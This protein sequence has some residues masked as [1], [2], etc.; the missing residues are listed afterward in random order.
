MNSLKICVFPDL[1]LSKEVKIGSHLATIIKDSAYNIANFEGSLTGEAHCRSKIGIKLATDIKYFDFFHCHNFKYVSM[2]NNHVFDYRKRGYLATVKALS[3]IGVESFGAGINSKDAQKEIII[4]DGGLRVSVIGVAAYSTNSLI[5][6]KHSFGCND[7]SY[8][9]LRSLASKTNANY[10]I[11]FA[12]VGIEQ[13]NYPEPYVRYVCE[14]LIEESCYDVII[15]CHAHALQGAAEINGRFVFYGLGNFLLPEIQYEGGK[16]GHTKN[17]DY[18]SFIVI[19]IENDKITAEQKYFEILENGT[20]AELIDGEEL[21][22]LERTMSD[23]TDPL[24][25]ELSE[26]TTWYSQHV[27]RVCFRNL[28]YCEPLQKVIQ[29][30]KLTCHHI[31]M[32]LYR[33]GGGL[34][35]RWSK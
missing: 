19:N 24:Y 6:G 23:Y 11:L 18:G 2:A 15:C 34:K 17:S 21:L 9:N 7:F 30:I 27:H 35:R 12:H 25:M 22:T 1:C 32:H 3:E 10:K 5:A 4:S 31:E 8:K 20:Y 29:R 33:I 16:L 28:V 26:Y 13:D 14:K